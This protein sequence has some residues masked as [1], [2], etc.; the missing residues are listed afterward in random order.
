MITTIF[1]RHS[2][3]GGNPVNLKF[4]FPAFA[5]MTNS[6]NRKPPGSRFLTF[7]KVVSHE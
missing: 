3:E 5:K 6:E 7:R 4:W 2:R 1:K